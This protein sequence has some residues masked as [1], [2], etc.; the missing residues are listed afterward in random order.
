MD[1]EPR[2]NTAAPADTPLLREYCGGA[3]MLSF[4]LAQ[5]KKLHFRD[6]IF[7]AS[8]SGSAYFW[9]GKAHETEELWFHY[10]CSMP[11]NAA[12]SCDF[13]ANLLDPAAGRLHPSFLS[14]WLTLIARMC[15]LYMNASYFKTTC[16]YL[17]PNLFSLCHK[18]AY[19]W[20][21]SLYF[22][23]EINYRCLREIYFTADYRRKISS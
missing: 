15:S 5:A 3:N 11:E 19:T 9:A 1:K 13:C 20:T 2:E 16:F 23:S 22:L 8:R 7:V 4:L 12:N 21:S 10:A 17:V 18:I 6:I 14:D